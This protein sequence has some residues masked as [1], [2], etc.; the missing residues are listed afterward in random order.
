MSM[1]QLVSVVV[2]GQIP[3]PDWPP[4][5]DFKTP[6]DYVAWYEQAKR[7]AIQ[8]DASVCKLHEE[9]R[10]SLLVTS[11][12]GV[13]HFGFAGFLHDENKPKDFYGGPWDPA[14]HPAWEASY[15]KSKAAL[16]RFK[17]AVSQGACDFPLTFM[18]SDQNEPRLLMNV[19]LRH[20]RYVR[21]C[22]KGL[23]EGAWRAEGGRADPSAVIEAG[24]VSL[25]AAD[26]IDRGL[27][28]M[29]H[30][31][32]NSIRS[33]VY[34]Q[35]REALQIPAFSVEDRAAV[36]KMF[37]KSDL[38]PAPYARFLRAEC[39][40]L[41]DFVQY[42]ADPERPLTN[43]PGLDGAAKAIRLGADDPA[44]TV[45]LFGAYFQ[46]VEKLTQGRSPAETVRRLDRAAE[47]KG[48]ANLTASILLP[49]LSASYVDHVNLTCQRRATRLL[50]EVF[51]YR[52]VHGKW[53]KR[54]QELRRNVLDRFGTDPWSGKRFNYRLADGGPL[55]YSVAA[56]GKDDRGKH[57]PRWGHRPDDTPARADY[58]FWPTQGGD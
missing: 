42:A 53:P 10:A 14:E 27:Y 31:V 33:L 11:D 45:E 34:Q 15:Q 57:D 47:Q 28:L 3:V 23:I 48:D 9:I 12:E 25:R 46:D 35:L 5:P 56:N 24:E 55:L 2:L 49:R 16:R 54:L 43:V 30:L 37:A 26:Q 4:M 21:S 44:K 36:A 17:Q 8:N 39:A 29:S 19:S 1:I 51:A 6:V 50:Y 52:D 40:A 58:V 32:A 18:E 20:L 38:E 41:L 7:D 13:E 22:V